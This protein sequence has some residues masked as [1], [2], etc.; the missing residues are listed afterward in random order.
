VHQLEFGNLKVVHWFAAFANTSSNTEDRLFM[1]MEELEQSGKSGEG[2]VVKL[3]G[4]CQ[5]AELHQGAD[6][7]N[8]R[9]GS[10]SSNDTNDVTFDV[11]MSPTGYLL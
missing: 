10:L 7:N 3:S 1:L 8:K 6:S 5:I 9:G 11:S 2:V 4:L